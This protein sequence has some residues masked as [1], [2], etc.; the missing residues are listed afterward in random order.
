MNL[1]VVAEKPEARRFKPPTSL[2]EDHNSILHSWLLY[3]NPPGESH[4]IYISN[5]PETVRL[6]E[7]TFDDF[8]PRLLELMLD[9]DQQ[10]IPYVVISL[11]LLCHDALDMMNVDHYPLPDPAVK[12][13]NSINGHKVNFK[14]YIASALNE[15]YAY[16]HEEKENESYIVQ[17][18]NARNRKLI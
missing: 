2:S 17:V 4:L 10:E 5:V 13:G 16:I 3:L 11:G 18:S 15:C 14:K 1:I 6:D 8:G 7:Q 9:F 12:Y